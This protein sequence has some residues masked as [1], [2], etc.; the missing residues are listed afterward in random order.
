[1]KNMN[2]CDGKG[3]YTND[4]AIAKQAFFDEDIDA[5]K[6][7]DAKIGDIFSDPRY[8]DYEVPNPIEIS[9]FI[10]EAIT[11]LGKE[12]SEDDKKFFLNRWGNF[13]HKKQ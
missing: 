11:F 9:E 5:L 8:S 1:M 2:Q 12:H 4:L 3:L 6:S 10:D 13:S 7:V